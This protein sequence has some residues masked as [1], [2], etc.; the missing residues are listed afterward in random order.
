AV[1]DPGEPGQAFEKRGRDVEQGGELTHRAI[2]HPILLP[3]LPHRKPVSVARTGDPELVVAGM[4]DV[5]AVAA[6]LLTEFGLQSLE[7]RTPLPGALGT[8]LLV[9]QDGLVEQGEVRHGTQW[10]IRLPSQP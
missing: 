4:G 2:L 1:L 9:R 8:F 10:E 7:R 3:A 6:G 5:R